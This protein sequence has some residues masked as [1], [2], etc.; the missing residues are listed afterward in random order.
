MKNTERF[1]NRVENY[2]KYRPD[3]PKEFIDYLYSQVGFSKDSIIAD[4]G[5]G[6]GILTRLLLER[7]SRVVGVEPNKKMRKA[8]EILLE[9]Y[10]KFISM[11]GTAETTGISNEAVDYVICATSFHWFNR[12][13]CKKEFSRILKSGG[14]V[15]LVWNKRIVEESRFLAAYEEL[16]KAYLPEY[17]GINHGLITDDEF[18]NF[19]KNRFYNSFSFKNEQLFD[20]EGLKGRLMSSSYAPMPG[21]SNHDV[22]MQGLENIFNKYSVEGKVDFKYTTEG[23]IGEV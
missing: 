12:E 16:L 8:A 4:I 22:L 7:G 15:V 11:D 19:F 10:P 9:E 6:T 17:D 3:Y 5:S 2:V 20:L 18:K 23:Y 1:S 21:E 14:K 13:V